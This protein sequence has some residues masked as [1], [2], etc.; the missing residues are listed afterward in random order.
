MRIHARMI[1]TA[2]LL[3]L[4]LAFVTTSGSPA[5]PLYGTIAGAASVSTVSPARYFRRHGR[6]CYRKCYREFVIG[7]RVCRTFC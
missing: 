4:G 3:A 1:A 2:V 6:L 5:A 7:R